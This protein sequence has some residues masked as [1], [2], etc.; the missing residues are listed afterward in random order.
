MGTRTLVIGGSGP[1]GP[2]ILQGLLDRGHE[3]TM[4]H[5]GTHEPDD[6]PDVEHLHGDPHFSDTLGEAIG[7]RSF[8]VVVA[9]YG[10]MRVVG[11]Y[12]A[13]RTGQLVCVGGVPVYR[14]YV[15]PENCSPWG[16][17]LNAREDSPLVD[18]LD[19][20]PTHAKKILDAERS[21]LAHA[22]TGA[23]RASYVRYPL[24]YGPRNVVPWEWA[25]LKRVFDGRQRMIL[26]DDGL[27]VISR[28]AAPNAAAAV[29]AM[30]DHPDTA[31]GQAYN[32]AD[33]QQLTVRQW[34]EKVTALVGG[35]LEFVGIP[36]T[37][38]PS[39]LNELH[40]PGSRPHMLVD[41]SKIR[42][43]L[44]Y[45]DVVSVDEFLSQTVEW[46]T[47][48][49][50]TPEQYPVYT[51]VFDYDREDQLMAAWAQTVERFAEIGDTAPPPGHPM[52]HPKQRLLL[53]DERGR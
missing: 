40:T 48:N 19:V 12:F 5:R 52:P 18:T 36:S 21:V 29:L 15:E 7:S 41:T 47:A 27:W 35:S 43:H 37:L 30:V 50:P 46:I 2:H 9:T 13:G 23:F 14:G 45:R 11:D 20:P 39:V 10:R 26:P 1:T 44:G 6:L 25:V 24:V 31:D 16:M 51:A 22:A 17:Q 53:R 3:V 32:I 42:T 38:A 49:R 33:E 28:V 34:A 4:L 8:D